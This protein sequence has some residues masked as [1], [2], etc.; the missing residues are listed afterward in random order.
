[1][2]GSAALEVIAGVGDLE[3]QTGACLKAGDTLH[4]LDH[5]LALINWRGKKR[6]QPVNG[7]R[8]RR[9]LG[10]IGL[11]RQPISSSTA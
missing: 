3:H 8:A 4:L 2:P 9:Q 5:L 7:Y 10:A 6:L 11:R 1:L